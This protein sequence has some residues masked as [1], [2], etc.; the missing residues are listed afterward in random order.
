MKKI[1][2]NPVLI[3]CLS[4]IIITILTLVTQQTHLVSRAITLSL[5][6]DKLDEEYTVSAQVI[7]A[8]SSSATDT[9]ASM[10][11]L[12]V[13]ATGKTLAQAMSTIE[14]KTGKV[15]NVSHCNVLILSSEVFKNNYFPSIDFL[16]THWKLPEQS[17]LVVAK[18]SA[19]EVLK[20]KPPEAKA[21]GFQIQENILLNKEDITGTST[22]TK[23]FLT[24]VFSKS[25]SSVLPLITTEKINSDNVSK[26]SAD[27]DEEYTEFDF[28]SSL[29]VGK[30]KILELDKEQT[31]TL[32]LVKTPKLKKGIIT[33]SHEDKTFVFNV[34]RVLN[35]IKCSSK[36]GYEAT[37]RVKIELS[38]KDISPLTS[39]KPFDLKSVLPDLIEKI[40][41]EYTQ[42]INDLYLVGKE[43]N[44]DLYL[45]YSMF[46][47]QCGTKFTDFVPNSST[48]FDKIKF[49]T[50]VKVG[51][52]E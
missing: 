42:K 52:K 5:A 20:A 38:I 36:N 39:S 12:V 28:S 51:I 15:L 23:S 45:L 35:S 48:F 49:N 44:I 24:E 27:I 30:N 13:T 4:V 33:I 8:S 9:S 11:Y 7:T 29:A 40:T 22:R 18:N 43:N 37:A 32:N 6:I 31:E 10:G 14:K 21:S 2:S 46:Y 3:L 17:L 34:D 26:E 50:D 41:R 1:Y 16:I 25:Q 47:S 19:S